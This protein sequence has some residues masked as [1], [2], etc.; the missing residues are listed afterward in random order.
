VTLTKTVVFEFCVRYKLETGGG[1]QF[2]NSVS[3]NNSKEEKG[4]YLKLDRFC[5][6]SRFDYSVYS[7]YELHKMETQ[8][9]VRQ[10]AVSFHRTG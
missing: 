5:V 4:E 3:V 7:L 8:P 1:G 10:S 6:R 9:S 2:L